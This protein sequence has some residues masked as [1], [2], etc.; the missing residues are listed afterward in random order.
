MRV[1]KCIFMIIGTAILMGGCITPYTPEIRESV[2]IMVINGLITDREGYQYVEVARSSAVGND[3]S[4]LPVSDCI[5]EVQ[6]DR[7][8]IFSFTEADPGIYASW[9]TA[10]DLVPG[11]E[12]KLTVTTVEGRQYHSEFEELLPCPPIDSIIWEVRDMPTTDPNI[13]YEGVQFHIATD[14]T[15][16][17][18]NNY[19]WELEETWEY[20]AA[21]SIWGYFD[22]SISFGVFPSDSLR[23]CW[24]T[25]RINDFFTYSTRNLSSNQITQFPINYISNQTDKL[26]IKY[27]LMVKQY[28][29]TETAYELWKIL[30]GQSKQSGELYATQPVRISGNIT[31][32]ENPAETVLGFFSASSATEKRIILSPQV[33]FLEAPYCLPYGLSGD[34][35]MDFLSQIS[36]YYYPVYLYDE[37]GLSPTF[38]YADQACFDCRMLGGTTERPDFWR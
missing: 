11:T 28:S 16:N 35:L 15:G 1:I 2:E 29:L 21:Y 13:T 7:G 9:M 8:G 23:I 20:H 34:S 3:E 22:G 6:D 31:S 33:S 18:A 12:Y 19:R 30:E 5:V 27:S 4:L 14:A 24:N 17:Y 37:G 10:Q 26:K 36:P 25:K 32:L 38:D